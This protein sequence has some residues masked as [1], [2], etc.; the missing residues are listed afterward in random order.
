MLPRM[1]MRWWGLVA[2]QGAPKTLGFGGGM[3]RMDKRRLGCRNQVRRGACMASCCADVRRVLGFLG[4]N[5][6]LR[7]ERLGTALLIYDC[8]E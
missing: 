4:S 3:G 2:V 6:S 7:C 5:L 1:R 8:A